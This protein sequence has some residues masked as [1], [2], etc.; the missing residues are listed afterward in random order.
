MELTLRAAAKARGTEGSGLPVV[1]GMFEASSGVGIAARLASEALTDLGI[2]HR[3]LDVTRLGATERPADTSASA[4]MMHLNPP[5]LLAV[6]YAWGPS[7]L[8]GP[9]S[10]IGPGSCPA[11]RRPGCGP[12]PW[13][14][15]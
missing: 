12:A 3:R 6:L 9:S 14:M 15:A 4:W 11:R 8:L 5:E 10:A 2:A 1:V 13:S 7:T